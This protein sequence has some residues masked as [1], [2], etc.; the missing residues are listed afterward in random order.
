MLYEVITGVDYDS[1]V[2]TLN[3][4]GTAGETQTIT[5][6]ITNDL[7]LEADETF[8]VNLVSSNVLIDDSDT[9][10][11]TITDNDTANAVLS[12]TTQ[13]DRNNFV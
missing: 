10:I 13:G 4:A 9:A 2:G 3:F 5:L 11:G 8:T 1:S 6:N 12:V 7:L